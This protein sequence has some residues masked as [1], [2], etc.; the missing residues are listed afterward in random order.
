MDVACGFAAATAQVGP[1][2]TKAE[3][4]RAI[5][6]HVLRDRFRWL[7]REAGELC[8]WLEEDIGFGSDFSAARPI[9]KNKCMAK[10]FDTA[11]IHD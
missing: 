11:E 4:S 9:R 7:L 6:S 1:V 8:R 2:E 3:T 5:S 10:R